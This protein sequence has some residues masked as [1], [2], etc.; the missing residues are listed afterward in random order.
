MGIY[1]RDTPPYHK[2]E[3]V[4]VKTLEGLG[5]EREGPVD[6][7][8]V[9]CVTYSETGEFFDLIVERREELGCSLENSL[10]QLY[11]TNE[12]EIKDVR[13]SVTCVKFSGVQ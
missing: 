7:G 2:E 9:A 13:Y 10:R 1:L 12:F 5:F 11:H 6:S 3:R 8:C 4:R